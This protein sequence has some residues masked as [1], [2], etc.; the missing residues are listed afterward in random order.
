[1]HLD[2]AF[3]SLPGLVVPQE[4]SRFRS[5]IDPEWIESALAATGT[6]TLRK[7]RLPAEQVLWIVIGMALM[8]DESIERV[9][10]QLDLALP[11]GNANSLVARSAITQARQR[12]GTEPLEYLFASLASEWAARSAAEHR[13]RGLALYGVDGTTLR[14]PDNDENWAA[15]GGQCGNGSRAG[16]AYPT[17]RVAALMVLRSHLLAAMSFGPYATGEITLAQDLWSAMPENS[18]VIVD[19]NFANAACLMRVGEKRHWLTRAR[20]KMKLRV[21]ER[22]GDGDDIV[23]I[24]ASRSTRS[25]HPDLPA[26]WTARAIRYQRR[27][28]RPSVLVTSLLDPRAFPAN[29]IVALYHERWELELGYDEIKTHMLEREE[30]IRSRTPDGVRQ[31]LWG[32]AIA[33]NLIRREMEQAANEAQVE[34]TRI[35]FVN[36]LSMIR[37]AWQLSSCPPQAPGKIPSRLAT[38]RRNL[39]LLVLPPRRVERSYPRAVKLKMSNYDKKWVRRAVPK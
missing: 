23:E 26:C 22:L 20:T 15:F 24:V 10:A 18:L 3:L 13:W 25:A 6:A 30:T 37:L 36:A 4:F 12:L 27:G 31:E 14:V 16:S 39:K 34:P 9:V 7:R 8:R 28:F 2:D 38:L 32:I 29:E 11:A 19:R 33:Y 5:G 17:V 35:S 21:L 1:M